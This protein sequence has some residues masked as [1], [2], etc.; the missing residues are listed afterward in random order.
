MASMRFPAPIVTFSLGL[1]ALALAACTK[2]TGSGTGG[3]TTGSGGSGGAAAGDCFDYT[4]FQTTP[5]VSF[6]TQV[7]PIFRNSCGISSVCH[8]CDDSDTCTDSGVKPYL[9]PS[10]GSP[11]PTAAQIAAIF[12]QTVDQPAALQPSL[13]DPSVMVGDPDMK[14]VAAGDPAH[15]FMMYKLDGDP[16]A[17]NM[18]DEVS[19]SKLTCAAGMTCGGAMP[20][21]GPQLTSSDRDIIRRWIAQGA[22]NN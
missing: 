15:S 22:K 1:A 14:I 19:C 13:I 3:H 12:A 8:G 21:G 17:S 20:S 11:D 9:G 18:N 16:T 7:L 4:G 6:G 2:S 5:A 10:V